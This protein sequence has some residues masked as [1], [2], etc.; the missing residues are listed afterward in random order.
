MQQSNFLIQLNKVHFMSFDVYFLIASILHNILCATNKL[1]IHY[2]L[3]RQKQL[4]KISKAETKTI[5]K[6]KLDKDNA[7]VLLL[8]LTY[9][10]YG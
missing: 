6:N 7:Y 3:I 10:S 1:N 9:K 5:F 4:Q 8:L 2:Y